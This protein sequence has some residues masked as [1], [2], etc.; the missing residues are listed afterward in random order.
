MKI[1]IPQMLLGLYLVQFVALGIN[2]YS[3][4]VWVA[5]NIPIVKFDDTFEGSWNASVESGQGKCSFGL[6]NEQTR[7]E[8]KYSGKFSYNVVGSV[9]CSISVTFTVPGMPLKIGLWVYGEDK[10]EYIRWVE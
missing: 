6:N 10:E 2:P 3:R 5:E 8:N 4:N 7:D 1:N 9:I